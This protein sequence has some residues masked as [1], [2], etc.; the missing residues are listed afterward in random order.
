MK[1][2]KPTFSATFGKVT[3]TECVA[4]FMAAVLTVT[5]AAGLARLAFERPA[6]AQTTA[7]TQSNRETL[8]LSESYLAQSAMRNVLMLEMKGELSFFEEESETIRLIEELSTGSVADTACSEE[9]S[10]ETTLAEETTTNAP[11]TTTKVREITTKAPETTTKKPV[12]TTKAPETIVE[13][14]TI[15]A[16]DVV[17]EPEGEK[18]GYTF[19]ELGLTQ[20]S[21]IKVPDDILFDENGI[22]LNYTRKLTGKSTAYHMGTTTAT[23]TRVH[24]GVVAVNP[25]IIPYGTKMYI[26]G[27]DGTVY[28]YS[29]A[30]DTGGF[31]HWNNAPIADLYMS[32]TNA[33]YAWGNKRVTIY[34]F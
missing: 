27:S 7:D 21:D 17:A 22:P 13:N 25:K 28:G 29:S 8:E 20:I 26:V 11:E 34:I 31:I 15:N 23:G 5:S 4:F 19:S 14:T 16:D 32:S 18:V 24:P 6:L 2:V 10:E 1:K 30:E 33:C 3:V 12:T 9:V